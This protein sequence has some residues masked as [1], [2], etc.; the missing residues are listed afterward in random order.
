MSISLVVGV[1]AAL[2]VPQANGGSDLLAK[3]VAA[4]QTAKSLDVTFTVRVLPAAGA[5]YRL[6]FSRPAML[7]ID[8]P[9]GFL[10]TDGSTVW[11]YWSESNSYNQRPGGIKDLLDELKDDS[12]AAWAAFFLPDQFKKVEDVQAGSK[13]SM[14]GNPVIPVTF[15]ID[16]RASLTGTLYIDPKSG[17]ARGASIKAARGGDSVEQLIMAKQISVGTTPLSASAFNFTAPAGAEEVEY[18]AAE[19]AKWYEDLD[20]ALKVA[21][22]T[23]RMLYVEFGAVW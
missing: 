1:A 8:R 4:L 7:R 13:I 20:E 12:L 3:H 15:T 17:I 18:S 5:E 10:L 23:N 2:F 6:Q 16:K 19:L 21:Q 22:A 14:L 9:D 11:T